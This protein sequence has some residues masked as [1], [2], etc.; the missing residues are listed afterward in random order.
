MNL[1]W[2]KQ[3][4]N[5]LTDSNFHSEARKLIA[6]IEDN[7]ELEKN[8][9]DPNKPDLGEPGYEEWEK[10]TH[11]VLSMVNHLKELMS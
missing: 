5:A 9:N 3:H 11:G 2:F 4:M 1:E 6:I 7:P 8:P 10:G